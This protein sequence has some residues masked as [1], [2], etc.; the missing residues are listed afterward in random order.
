MAAAPLSAVRDFLP[1]GGTL[2]HEAFAP[3]QRWLVCLLGLHVPALAAF[4]AWRGFGVLELLVAVIG[5]AALAW[6][7]DSA[8]DRR[9]GSAA[10]AVGL[11]VSSGVLL[12]LSDGAA[13]ARF[14]VFVVVVVVA[15]Y[16]DWVP[17]FLVTVIGAAPLPWHGGDPGPK[18][19]VH[20]AAVVAACVGQVL[21]LRATQREER[22]NARLAAELAR[23][24]SEVE[25]RES[26]SELFIN[27]ARR[28]QA[29]LDRQINL[30]VAMQEREA[31]PDQLAEL[32]ALD[33]L[34]TRI[35]RN[36]ESLLVLS[37]EESPRRWGRPV[38]LADVV[39]AGIA[40]VEDYRR[41]DVVV[42]EA[43]A[44]TGRAVADIAHLLAE[45]VEN[46]LQF[47]PPDTR[48]RVASTPRAD[49]G[50]T[51]TVEDRG[52]GLPAVDLAGANELLARAPEVDLRLSKRLGLHVISRL[53]ARY[54]MRVTL[55]ATAGGGT[56][57][58]VVIPADL[59]APAEPVATA[60]ASASTKP[61]RPALVATVAGRPLA[62]P[63]RPII[64]PALVP[65]TSRRRIMAAAPIAVPDPTPALPAV[66]AAAAASAQVPAPG[67]LPRRVPQ[68]SLHPQILSGT[69]P[70]P[71]V[72]AVPDG[73]RR[74]SPDE[75]RSALS[76]FQAGQQ[77]GREEALV[78]RRE[79]DEL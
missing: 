1:N 61:R 24:Q 53:A 16:Q 28:N 13:E 44:V 17:L 68:A 3:R 43:V 55:A 12:H 14:H 57:A 60:P 20:A 31:D 30:V 79:G 36:A 50:C 64:E 37:G 45:L 21:V 6:V 69:G 56:T 5:P 70:A 66:A 40:E 48:V 59:L 47:S 27:L 10:V 29:L 32:F 38:A 23:T 18:P 62:A 25:A 41:A 7:G 54:G 22:K 72:P 78:R 46:G 11:A 77:R 8:H 76:R 33:H 75:I 35:R 4:G 2:D 58:T 63:T 19:I 71:V 26:A 15:L 52:I 67:G 65:P 51:L 74:R 73:A 49:G 9:L 34:A 39:R 42:D